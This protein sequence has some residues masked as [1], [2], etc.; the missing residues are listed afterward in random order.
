MKPLRSLSLHAGLL[1]LSGVAA[2]FAWSKDKTPRSAQETNVTVWN[3]RPS[4]V[5]R[6]VHETKGK[7]V[8]LEARD[9]KKGERWYYGK[10]EYTSPPGAI[11]QPAA[12]S[13]VF[14]SVGPATKV[15]EAFA[16]FKALRALGKVPDSRAAEFG[17]DKK[18]TSVT[19]TISGKERKLFIGS[20]APGSGDTYALDPATSEGYVLKSD[21]LR[22]LEGG[23]SR[24]LEREQHVFKDSDM[25]SAKITAGG[26][27]RVIVRGGPEGKKFWADPSDK[28]KNDETLGNW[29]Q[30]VDHLRVTEFAAKPPEGRTVLVRIDFDGAS[31]NL[32]YFE[33]SKA[34]STDS[35]AQKGDY[36]IATEHTHLPGK[37]P[38]TTGEQVEQDL[39]SILK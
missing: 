18:D 8:D 39:V 17:F 22:D 27:S 2:A 33:L 35:S 3:A 9:E 7:K 25:T 24:L 37:I 23:E 10:V 31:G 36:W 12:K 14:A 1:V 6:I 34:P 15:V 11:S 16:P 19:L 21:P 5:S 29:M 20:I 38:A 30:K 28:E 32:G 4:D 26:K 13:T